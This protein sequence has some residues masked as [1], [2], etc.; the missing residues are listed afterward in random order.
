MWQPSVVR[1]MWQLHLYVVYPSFKFCYHGIKQVTVGGA[2][3]LAIQVTLI[4]FDQ[5]HFRYVNIENVSGQI[6]PKAP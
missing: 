2:F 1:K 6:A 4:V 5:E 3:H